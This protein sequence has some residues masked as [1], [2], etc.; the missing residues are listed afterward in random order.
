MPKFVADGEGKK[1]VGRHAKFRAGVLANGIYF[2][3]AR[4]RIDLRAIPASLALGLLLF[5]GAEHQ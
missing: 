1:L 3:A 4:G 2:G 5:R